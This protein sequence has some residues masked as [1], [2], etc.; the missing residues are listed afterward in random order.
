[1]LYKKG[2]WKKALIF[3]DIISLFL[4]VNITS[5][6]INAIQSPENIQAA[7]LITTSRQLQLQF[8][9]LLFLLWG[10]MQHTWKYT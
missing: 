3:V 8:F 9:C 6:A 10:K 4:L 5:K 1:M 7:S 2:N